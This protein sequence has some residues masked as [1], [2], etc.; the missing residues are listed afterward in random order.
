MRRSLSIKILQFRRISLQYYDQRQGVESAG[1]KRG[2]KPE[3]RGI[4]VY[5]NPP[6]RAGRLGDAQ[7]HTRAVRGPRAFGERPPYK[8]L[9]PGRKTPGVREA[10]KEGVLH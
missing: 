7:I 4:A 10:H 1:D 8:V 2:R 5:D 3:G 6:G 9:G